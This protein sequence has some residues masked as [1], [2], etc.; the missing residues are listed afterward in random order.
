M[1]EDRFV[2][3]GASGL[4]SSWHAQGHAK[5]PQQGKPVPGRQL[6]GY[7][8]A[9][10]SRP[11][12]ACLQQAGIPTQPAKNALKDSVVFPKPVRYRIG[13]VPA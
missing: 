7:E 2:I 8:D 10:N 13:P 6:H 11:W 5:T 9:L 12:L 4:Q 1:E 3:A